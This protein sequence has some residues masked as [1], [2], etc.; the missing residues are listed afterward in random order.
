[1]AYVGARV[2]A[3]AIRRLCFTTSPET[4][5]ALYRQKTCAESAVYLARIAYRYKEPSRNFKTTGFK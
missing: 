1:M 4:A 3:V 5:T 2:Q